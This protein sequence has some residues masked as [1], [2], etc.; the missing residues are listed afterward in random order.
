[1]KPH[2]LTRK[3]ALPGMVQAPPDQLPAAPALQT[4]VVPFPAIPQSVVSCAVLFAQFSTV[5]MANLVLMSS[6]AANSLAANRQ[7]R[8]DH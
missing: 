4:D 1:M 8:E 3:P 6:L 5:V 2:T 7:R